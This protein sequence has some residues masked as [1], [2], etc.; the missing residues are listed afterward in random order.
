MNGTDKRDQA[1]DRLLRQ[2]LTPASPGDPSACLD[3]ETVAAWMDGTL[4]GP[5]LDAAQM[6][7]ADCDRCQAVLATFAQMNT[8]MPAAAPEPRRWLTWL[9]PLTAAAAIGVW[10]LL[11][12]SP[13]VT[14]AP[15]SMMARGDEASRVPPPPPVQQERETKAA[16]QAPAA[17]PPAVA[18]PGPP[19]AQAK[20]VTPE[21]RQDPAHPEVDAFR[22]RDRAMSGAAPAAPPAAAPAA[23]PAPPGGVVGSLAETITLPA[24]ASVPWRVRGTIVE[25]SNDGG[26]S[27]TTAYAGQAE[28]TMAAPVSAQV[29]WVVGRAGLVLRTTDGRTFTRLNFPETVDLT[30]VRATSETSATVTTVDGRTLTTTDGGVSWRR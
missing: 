10:A 25:Q 6:H 30:A 4:R 21:T 12:A 24:R 26:V 22:L 8:P 16:A 1:V 20:E 19:P 27:W 13:P 28:L 23:P 17:A 2:S 7:A 14:S 29:C 9:V 11:P 3:A 15:E 5:A 18:S